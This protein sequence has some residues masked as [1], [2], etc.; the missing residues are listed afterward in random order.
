[1]KFK[2][3][4]SILSLLLSINESF[5]TMV[6]FELV[7]IEEKDHLVFASGNGTTSRLFS[8]IANQDGSSSYSSPHKLY[9]PI[10]DVLA[11]SEP[12]L[13]SAASSPSTLLE[14][15][16]TTYSGNLTFEI[17]IASTDS[18]DKYLYAAYST[19]SSTDFKVVNLTNS[20]LSSSNSTGTINYTKSLSFPALC[21]LDGTI[22]DVNNSVKDIN[23]M[24]FVSAD[25][26]IAD[27]SSINYDDNKAQA[28][29]VTFSLSSK[30]ND[31]TPVLHDLRKGDERLIAD[32]STSLAIT[33]VYGTAIYRD[34]SG[35]AGACSALVSSGKTVNDPTLGF[36]Q[37]K[38]E[39]SGQTGL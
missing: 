18:S 24:F 1:M 37:F 33:S 36:D 12:R 17:T 6:Y 20:S 39:N 35:V 30:V 25:E 8:D 23:M 9:I 27:N 16:G 26:L 3:I 2:L 13:Y 32:F 29:F 15:S 19:G 4:L 5:A 22:C 28:V 7:E 34:N 21:T 11:A 38:I 14:K 10:N 31:T